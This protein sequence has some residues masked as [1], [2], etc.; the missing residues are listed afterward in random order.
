MIPT[1]DVDAAALVAQ[2]EEGQGDGRS[3]IAT[4]QFQPRSDFAKA[5]ETASLESSSE[6][7][8]VLNL[9]KRLPPAGVEIE[10]RNL[11]P[12]NGGSME[13]MTQF[14]RLMEVHLETKRDFEVC[15]SY[16][17]LFIKLHR[18]VLWMEPA[19]K[20]SLEKTRK[21]Q[22]KCWTR[23]DDLLNDTLSLV[24]YLKSSVL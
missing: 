17:G 19:L 8:S 21:A 12:I 18:D 23:L 4:T 3:R 1:F 22:T 20:E 24:T 2:N 15:N 13:L 10:L 16:L 14:L 5:L 9:L 6:S 11:A 7:E